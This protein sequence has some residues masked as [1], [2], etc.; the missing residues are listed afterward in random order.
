MFDRE[1]LDKLCKDLNFGEKTKEFIWKIMTSPPARAVSSAKTIIGAFP[2]P[3]AGE[4]TQFESNILEFSATLKYV[5]GYARFYRDQPISFIVHF[6]TV[7]GKNAA[8]SHVP[9]F[10][11]IRRGEVGFEEWKMERRL[12][13]LA[14]KNPNR[15]KKDNKGV[16]H[17]PPGE[18]YARQYGLFY[19]IRTE[20]DINFILRRNTELLLEYHFSAD[21]RINSDIQ[22][23]VLQLVRAREGLSLFD[24]IEQT[25]KFT[26]SDTIYFMIVRKKLFVDLESQLLP[27]PPTANIY[28]ERS[29]CRAHSIARAASHTS[30]LSETKAIQLLPGNIVTMGTTCC[31]VLTADI[32]MIHL[33]PEKGDLIALERKNV[34]P[35]INK[36]ALT[37]CPNENDRN[38]LI[39][40]AYRTAGPKGIAKG[41]TRL[42]QLQPAILSGKVKDALMKERTAYLLLQL[43]RKAEISFGCGFI[44][45]LGSDR[46]PGNYS[47]KRPKEVLDDAV[48]HIEAEYLNIKQ[49]SPYACHKRYK[50][51]RMA[52]GKNYVSYNTYLALIAAIPAEEREGARKGSKVAYQ[53]EFIYVLCHETPIHG[54]R[55]LH[56]VHIDHTELSIILICSRTGKSLEKVWLTLIMD[57]FS[58]RVLAF[59][60]SFESPSYR[61]SMLVIRELIKRYNRSPFIIVSDRG[62]DF[63]KSVYYKAL[64]ANLVSTRFERPTAEPRHGAVLERLFGITE[65]EIIFSMTGNTQAL[66]EPRTMTDETNPELQAIWTFAR[67]E[68]KLSQFFY[69]TYDN[70]PHPALGVS[71]RE[72]FQQSLRMF[73]PRDHKYVAY[74]RA[75]YISTLPASPYD[76]VKIQKNGVKINNIWYT[77]LSLKKFIGKEVPAKYDPHNIGIAFVLIDGS[78]HEVRSRFYDVFSRLTESQLRAFTEEIMQRLNIAKR[79][80]VSDRMIAEFIKE[81]QLEEV[82]LKNQKM[83]RMQEE[84]THRLQNVPYSSAPSQNTAVEPQALEFEMSDIPD[85]REVKKL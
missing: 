38:R 72:M 20:K 3:R 17:F 4:T 55:C 79:S 42:E 39:L 81:L 60:L 65:H 70:M 45:L 30:V 74:D 25:E 34:I 1:T 41:L 77:S 50:T 71:P 2:D 9:D 29:L 85:Y 21:V 28:S 52:N 15:Y 40:D 31:T 8:H 63:A 69:E 43:Y 64:I 26:S 14:K 54:D 48:K 76:T 11:L 37:V 67:L 68:A 12:E 36:G 57:A 16:W 10:F 49:E 18:N 51:D 83:L 78:W 61:S 32:N 44:G 58:R 22:A 75:F 84:Q 46:N 27:D 24:L 6:L 66:K 7:K 23:K 33:Q 13:K 80:H 19:R 62:P 73:G 59:I 53:E 35:L 56:I 5:M 82:E 47:N